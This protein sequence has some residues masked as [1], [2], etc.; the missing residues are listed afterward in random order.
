MNDSYS[1]QWCSHGKQLAEDCDQCDDI[2]SHEEAEIQRFHD[3]LG[4]LDKYVAG[5]NGY[6]ES[7]VAQTGRECWLDYYN[8]GLSPAEAWAEDMSYADITDEGN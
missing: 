6:P 4:E 2:D 1:S 3:W 8:D 5:M 7:I